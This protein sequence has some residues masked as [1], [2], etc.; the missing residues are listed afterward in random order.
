V[1]LVAATEQELGQVRAVLAGDAGD[2]GYGH[3]GS[4]RATG[5]VLLALSV[6]F[7]IPEQKEHARRA[8]T[9]GGA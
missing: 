7:R 2:E 6:G 4:L 1:D 8:G 9:T 3:A 5:V